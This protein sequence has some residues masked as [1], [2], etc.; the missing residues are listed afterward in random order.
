M[1]GMVE[2]AF[3]AAN[4]A[5][6]HAAK[7]TSTFWPTRSA[8]NENPASS[9]GVFSLM[10]A[11]SVRDGGDHRSKKIAPIGMPKAGHWFVADSPLER[12]GFERSVP[13]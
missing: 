7:I 2:V 9:A 3:F 8:A 13:R 6:S 10:G 12:N 1:I 5:G 4:A 11:S